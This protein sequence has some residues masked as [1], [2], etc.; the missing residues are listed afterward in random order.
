MNCL[1][2]RR[3][4]LANPMNDEADLQAHLQE[5]TACR[6]FSI[7]LKRQEAQLREALAVPV[8]PHLAER[9]LLAT[10]LRRP[11]WHGVAWAASLLLT[12]T[13]GF[14]GYLKWPSQTPAAWS[15]VILAHVLNERDTL[16]RNDSISLDRLTTAL[17]DF[18]LNV[19]SE[20]GRIRY[21]DKCEMPG[22][23]GLHVVVDTRELGQVTL[24]LPPH[25]TQHPQ[26]ETTRD[27]FAARLVTLGG[28]T[29]GVVT[30]HPDQI[31]A[32]S[33]WLGQTLQARSI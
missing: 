27:G 7:D 4:L 3:A 31:D 23:K 14:G 19:K 15:E 28:T 12:I 9:V 16:S 32:L 2:V 13:I 22:G 26:G 11:R 21:L 30:E 18:G 24:I 10:R 25:G 29:V 5:C 1:E 33:H 6:S 8:P 20:V 17:A